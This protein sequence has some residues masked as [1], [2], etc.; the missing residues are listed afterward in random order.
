MTKICIA[1][2]LI[3]L[4]LPLPAADGDPAAFGIGSR[5]PTL[6]IPFHP[7]TWPILRASVS[8]CAPAILYLSL[9]DAI[10]LAIENNL[11]IE[12]QRYS[13]PMAT[14]KC[15]EQKAADCFED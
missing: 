3:L 8:C 13:L 15:C 2:F 12:L 10:A 11:D 14:P 1:I 6:S 7:W 5:E 9:S 4:R